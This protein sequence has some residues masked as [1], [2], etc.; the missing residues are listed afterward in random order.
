MYISLIT[1][2]FLSTS[3]LAKQAVTNADSFGAML[4]RGDAIA[5]R[6]GYYPDTRTCG[7]GN[8]C[9][10]ACGA[11]QVECPSSS[12]TMLYC[13]SSIDGSHCCTDGSGK[14]CR[15]G[16]YCTTDGAS[17]TYCCPDGIDTAECARQYSLTVSLIRESRTAALLSVTGASDVP[18]ET[19]A[20]STPIHVSVVPT[21]HTS[22]VLPTGRPNA[23]YSGPSPPEFTGGASK[24]VGAGFAV[25]AGAVGLF[26]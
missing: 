6:Q 26:L 18:A 11:N 9:E 8:T 5:K 16:F 3:A 10:E 17:N 7:R 21:A 24:V 25:L 2:A 23:T 19:P 14:S 20:I 4:R 22:L 1:L 12:L 13:H 15:A